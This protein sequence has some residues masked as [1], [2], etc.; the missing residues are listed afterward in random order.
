M[1]AVAGEREKPEWDALLGREYQWGETA[2]E[3]PVVAKKFDNASGAKGLCHSVRSV[4]QPRGR[5]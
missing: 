2:A 4:N 5:N 3:Q 1:Y